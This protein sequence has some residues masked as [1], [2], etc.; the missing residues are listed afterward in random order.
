MAFGKVIVGH[1]LDC[2]REPI[3]QWLRAYDEQLYLKWNP[4]KNAGKGLWEVRRRP[5]KKSQVY[6]GEI[7]PD[8][9][10]IECRYIENDMIHHVL[11]AEVLDW[12]IPQR[13]RDMD[14]RGIVDW[15]GHM[16]YEGARV[17]EKQEKNIRAEM[18]Y[19]IK[20]HRKVLRTWME[21]V[22]RGQNPGRVLNK[23]RPV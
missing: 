11:D 19:N 23:F 20:Q 7:A 13:I 12:R 3:E 17:M 1:T 8:V 10:L 2:K 4:N 18:K 21:D 9:A 15:V 16:E 22:A 14:T 5:T 6:H